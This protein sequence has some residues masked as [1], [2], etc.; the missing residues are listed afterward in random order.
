VFV[1]AVA[2]P[3]FYNASGSA[4]RELILSLVDPFER[5]Y[6]TVR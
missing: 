5:W 3:S 4:L 2:R 1:V 6:S